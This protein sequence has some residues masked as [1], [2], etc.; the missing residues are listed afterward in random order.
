MTDSGK[1]FEYRGGDNL[2]VM[3]EARVYNRFLT[4]QVLRFHRGDGPVLDF[5]AGIGTFAER[6]RARGLVV[7]CLELDRR[8]CDALRAQGFEAFE[9]AAGLAASSYDYVYSLNVFEH[10]EDDRAAAREVYRVLRPGGVVY[11]YVPAF[12]V[13]FGSMDR[14][15]E[16]C[17]RYRRRGLER[18]FGEAGFEVQTSAYVDCL[19]F[20]ATLAYNLLSGDDGGIRPGSV[21]FYDR[22]LFP[23]SRALDRLTAAFIGKNVYL[24]ARKPA[25]AGLAV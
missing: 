3:R 7:H 17:R 18:L 11:V 4:G 15:V 5:G 2:E 16:H 22:F 21:R 6:L 13:L 20:F 14:K 8:Q 19:G 24:V 25:P 12:Q 23:L 1:P 10:I 9:D